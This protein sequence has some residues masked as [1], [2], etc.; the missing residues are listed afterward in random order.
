MAQRADDRGNSRKNKRVS[1]G[2]LFTEK[3]MLKIPLPLEQ[4]LNCICGL[5]EHDCMD[6]SCL[7]N[8]IINSIHAEAEQKRQILLWA[9]KVMKNVAKGTRATIKTKG[10]K[11]DGTNKTRTAKGN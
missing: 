6:T 4:E 5:C 2:I 3:N 10:R 7:Y 9:E 8:K 11:T 1:K